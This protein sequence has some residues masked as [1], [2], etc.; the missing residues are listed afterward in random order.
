ML[1][2]LTAHLCQFSLIHTNL[3]PTPISFALWPSESQ[4]GH[5]CSLGLGITCSLE[6]GS[7]TEDNLL[8]ITKSLSVAHSTKA[9]IGQSHVRPF[10]THNWQL[11][12]P[13]MFRVNCNYRVLDCTPTFSSDVSRA[14]VRYTLSVQCPRSHVLSTLNWHESL[15]SP[16]L[17]SGEAPFS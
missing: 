5:L 10:L 12:E 14:L 3:F 16:L 11:T 8:R 2:L 13:I 1:Q 7:A 9:G 4:E 17:T 6:L 15:H